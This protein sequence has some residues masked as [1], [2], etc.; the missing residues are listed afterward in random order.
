MYKEGSIKT[1]LCLCI[2]FIQFSIHR[3]SLVAQM[4][5]NLTVIY[6]GPWFDSWVGKICWRGIGYSHQYSWAFWVAQLVKNSPT[7][8]ETCVQSLDWENPLE[9]GPGSHSSTLAWRI[10][11]TGHGVTKSQ[12]RLSDFH[13]TTLGVSLP[14]YRLEL[15]KIIKEEVR[16]RED[17]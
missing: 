11:W 14:S 13:Y 8:Q 4:L 15:K 10:P 9:N 3:S 2:L 7:M 12:T 5:K 1:H 17:F 6:R 16:G